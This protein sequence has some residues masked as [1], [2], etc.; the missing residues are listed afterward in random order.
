MFAG[1]CS[2]SFHGAYDVAQAFERVLFCN[3]YIYI[4][5]LLLVSISTILMWGSR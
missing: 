2:P 5:M 1:A 4:Y 3:I